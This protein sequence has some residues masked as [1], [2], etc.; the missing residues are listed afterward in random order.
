MQVNNGLDIYRALCA[1]ARRY[2]FRNRDEV[3]CYGLTVSQCYALQLLH[4]EG[5]SS[6][7]LSTML[8]LDISSVTRLVDQL[9]KKKL[10]VR[11]VSSE[12]GRVRLVQ[13]TDAGS[14][15]VRRIEE[16]F[17]QIVSQALA[18]LSPEVLKALPNALTQLAS[19]LETCAVS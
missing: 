15:L 10:V 5:M 4:Q 13:I 17:G 18:N 8:S 14:K 9:L 7:K 19:A 2:Q 11:E 12:D 6:T 1:L 16:D 3:C